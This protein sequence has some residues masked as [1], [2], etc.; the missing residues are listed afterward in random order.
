MPEE[1]KEKRTYTVN[2]VDGK[3]Q[4]IQADDMVINHRENRVSFVGANESEGE[5]VFFVTGVASIHKRSEAEA[6]QTESGHEQV[7]SEPSEP[8]KQKTEGTVQVVGRILG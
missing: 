4:T 5:W 8:E 2:T 1:K 3:T 6:G 7:E